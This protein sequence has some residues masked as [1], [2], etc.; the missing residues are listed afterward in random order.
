MQVVQSM[1]SMKG[2]YSLALHRG[3]LYGERLRRVTATAVP[4]A[5]TAK[6][7]TA[8]ITGGTA[9]LGFEFAKKVRFLQIMPMIQRWA[10]C[11]LL[12]K[13]QILTNTVHGSFLYAL[14]CMANEC[15]QFYSGRLSD[16]CHI[17]ALAQ[18]LRWWPFHFLIVTLPR[19]RSL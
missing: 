10:I 14:L 6:G 19:R 16:L 18:K 17:G 9:G 11:V 1:L 12:K 3:C 2:E 13:V 7:L 15:I 8:V 5:P 4:R